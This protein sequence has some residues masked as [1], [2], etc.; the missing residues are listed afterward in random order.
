MRLGALLAQPLANHQVEPGLEVD[1]QS[2][3]ADRALDD[4]AEFF[5]LQGLLELVECLV[6]ERAN[7]DFD[8]RKARHRD[9][10]NIGIGRA[11]SLEQLDAAPFGG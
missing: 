11:D 9:H 7:R 4:R 2:L 1:E 5:R 6:L 3:F 10:A 8:R